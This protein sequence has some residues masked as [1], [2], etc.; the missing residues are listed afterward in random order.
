MTGGRGEDQIQKSENS[1]FF[2]FFFKPSLNHKL[3]LVVWPRL[4]GAV[5]NWKTSDYEPYRI[6]GM[7]YLLL[8]FHF[9]Q[10][11]CSGK[12]TV[13][14]NSGAGTRKAVLEKVLSNERTT[15]YASDIIDIKS[16]FSD[17]KDC[18]WYKSRQT[19]FR[20]A[21]FLSLIHN[22]FCQTFLFIAHFP[23]IIADE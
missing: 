22:F 14:H 16:K 15:A 7:N 6:L 12:R 10:I 9:I 21:R 20:E 3:I 1:D 2:Y 8:I 13:S 19:I 4:Q 23:S 18:N 17:C 11:N 5:T